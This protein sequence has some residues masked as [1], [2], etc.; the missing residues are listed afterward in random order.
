MAKDYYKILGVGKNA[1]PD[2]IRASFRRLAHQ[3][4]PDQTRRSARNMTSTVQHLTKR[5][6]R[7]VRDLE[8]LDQAALLAAGLAMEAKV[9]NLIWVIFLE[10]FLE[11]AEHVREHELV[12]RAVLI[13]T[14]M[15][16]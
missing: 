1:S 6:R 13:S 16:N 10:M 15:P 9:L 5:V 7:A 3:Y 11:A 8:G 12:R 4:H 14:W 2:E